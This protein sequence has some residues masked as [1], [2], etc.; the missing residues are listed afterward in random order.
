MLR[1]DHA[2]SVS[3]GVVSIAISIFL[4][5]GFAA[6]GNAAEKTWELKM[7]HHAGAYITK[8]ALGG[9]AKNVED[10]TKGRVKIKIL[11]FTALGGVTEG[12]DLVTSGTA[13]V[14]WTFTGFFPGQFA[15]SDIMTLPFVTCPSSELTSGV[16]WDLTEKFPQEF[17]KEYSEVKLLTIHTSDPNIVGTTSKPVRKLEDLKGLNMRVSAGLT[18]F[19]K[20]L[21]ANPQMVPTGDTYLAFEKGVLNGFISD[22]PAVD[23]FKWYDVINYYTTIGINSNAYWI[24]MNKKVWNSM[25]EDVQKQVMSVS[26]RTGATFIGKVWDEYSK[27]IVTQVAKMPKKELIQLP[28]E[29]VARWR[30]L[31]EPMWESYVSKLE[32]KGSPGKKVLEYALQRVSECSK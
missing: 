26:G 20:A 1:K 15:L 27:S 30:K 13:D 2:F 24:I 3:A 17:G 22:W 28:G 31:A 18:D 14:A 16:L 12:Y 11:P 4:T 32:A 19:V 7:H 29:E 9:W 23:A 21:G 5:F 6:R 8:N 10:A 25:P